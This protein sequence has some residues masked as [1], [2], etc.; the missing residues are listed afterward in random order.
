MRLLEIYQRLLER[1]GKQDWW[2]VS[3]GFSPPEWEVC[4]G[5]ILTQNTNWKNV[6]RA[7]ENLKAEKIV[8][9]I[10]IIKT[11]TPQ[12]EKA[13]MPS[14]F[15]RQKG[16]RLQIFADFVLGFGDFRLFSNRVTREQLINVPG[17]GPE[18]ADSILL[19]ALGRPVFVIDAYTKRIFTRLGFAKKKRYEE[20]RLFFESRLPKDVGV[21]KEFHA[22]IVELAKSSCRPKPLCEDCVL[23]SHCINNKKQ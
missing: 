22:L 5:A 20:W 13:V 12:L 7:L 15:Y 23:N 14:G 9:P 1:F 8:T 6:E 19:Y 17:L 2:P 21:Y 18:T 16:R 4:L 3:N 10:D 11:K